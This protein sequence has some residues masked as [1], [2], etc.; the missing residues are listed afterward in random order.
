ME[1]DKWHKSMNLDE[2][3]WWNS[4]WSI[5]NTLD[6][7]IVVKTRTRY[8]FI[9]PWS[10]TL[11]DG[12]G[13]VLSMMAMAWYSPWWPWPGTLHDGN[14]L[15]LS[16][17]AMAWYSPWWPWPGTLHDGN[18]LVLF[19]MAMAWYSPWWQW[20]GTLH[21]GN[22]LVSVHHGHDDVLQSRSR[23]HIEMKQICVVLM[24]L[25]SDLSS[26]T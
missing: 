26:I 9:S 8:A 2:I 25:L 1:E 11:H 5:T 12:N 17:M 15:I 14:G 3:L 18:G 10:G 7:D 23:H 4:Q 19:M 16:M 24:D 13:L 22:V 21:D 6:Y 20:P